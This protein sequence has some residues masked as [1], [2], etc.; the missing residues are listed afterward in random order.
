MIAAPIASLLEPAHSAR[1][2]KKHRLDPHAQCPSLQVGKNGLSTAFSAILWMD[3][4]TADLTEEFWALH[5]ALV[6]S[7]V[8]FKHTTRKNGTITGQDKQV[9]ELVL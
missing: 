1:G 7:L 4:Y 2:E 3:S 5:A 6:L 8:N 9:R